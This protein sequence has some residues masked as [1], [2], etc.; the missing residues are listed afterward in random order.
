MEIGRILRLN[1]RSST[2]KKKKLG[3][4][5]DLGIY[6]LSGVFE[7]VEVELPTRRRVE[8]RHARSLLRIRRRIAAGTK[9]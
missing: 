4:I 8:R 3:K 1:F 2:Q 7:L 5:C 6:E 9:E